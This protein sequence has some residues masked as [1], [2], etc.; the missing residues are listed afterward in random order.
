MLVSYYYFIIIFRFQK[1]NIRSCVLRFS[2]LIFDIA[3]FFRFHRHHGGRLEPQRVIN[4]LII[5][6]MENGKRAR[7]DASF[8]SRE[9]AL[10]FR[11]ASARDREDGK[12]LTCFIAS[13]VRAFRSSLG[14]RIRAWEMHRSR[15]IRNSSDKGK[16][17]EREKI[18]IKL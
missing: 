1:D 17:S 8:H 4:L 3:R 5:P 7:Q 18:R 6:R 2:H 16:S 11:D 15:V 14:S 13:F 9:D 10:T 12:S